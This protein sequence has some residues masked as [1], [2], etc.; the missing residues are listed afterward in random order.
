MPGAND[1]A[2]PGAP[3]PGRPRDPDVD[4]AIVQ[5]TLRLLTARGYEGMSVEGVASAASVGKTAIYRR[6]RSKAE[7]AAAALETVKADSGPPPDTGSARTDLV[8]MMMQ[9]Q[10]AFSRGPVFA[11]LG[12]L[13]VEE[14]RNPKLFE[15]F[16]Q[17]IFLPR[18]D[19]GLAILRRG[20]KRGEIRADANLE[21]A[22]HAIVGALLTRH[23]LA[24]PE[25]R[26]LIEATVD[27]LW[28][29]LANSG[30]TDERA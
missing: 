14:R 19:D 12:A 1:P 17:R 13:L 2:T 30:A 28:T 24:V 3:K 7:L 5:A 11:M 26:T 4:L 9:A 15:L 21:V 20:V 18:R 8:E 6:Y 29:G 16:R 23:I 22:A 27:T 25:S 10:R